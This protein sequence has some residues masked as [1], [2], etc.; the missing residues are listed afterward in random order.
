MESC[1]IFAERDNTRPQ[2]TARQ[3]DTDAMRPIKKLVTDV[4]CPP[5]P[6]L[7]MPDF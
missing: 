7:R 2:T 4:T 6:K 3:L 5:I 1:D